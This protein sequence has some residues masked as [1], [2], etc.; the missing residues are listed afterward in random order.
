MGAKYGDQLVESARG[1]S[2][3]VESRQKNFDAAKELC[4]S[5][6]SVCNQVILICKDGSQIEQDSS[7][8]YPN[9]DGRIRCPEAGGQF[10]GAKICTRQRQ[11]ARWQNRRWSG[12]TS[13]NGFAIDDFNAQLLSRRRGCLLV[14]Q[15]SFRNVL[16][17]RSNFFFSQTHHSK[18]GNAIVISL[19]VRQ[20]GG[21][22]Y[23]V[24]EFVDAQSAKQRI[25]AHARDQVGPP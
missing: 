7:F 11:E 21:L 17:P 16:G 8:F 24:G 4:D 1:V 2:D 15:K 10:I 19:D 3:G 12:A 6:E 18:R 20:Q 23:G 5:P 13:D 9:D 22:E 25:G 14:C